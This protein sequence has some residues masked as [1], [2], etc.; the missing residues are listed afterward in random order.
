MVSANAYPVMGGVE[1]HVYEVAPRIAAAGFDVTILTTDL[2]GE[3]PPHDEIRGVPVIRVPARP[4][5]RDYYWAPD[6]YRTIRREKW[7]LVH[8]QGYHTLV[9]PL[10][11]AASARNKIPYVVTFHSGGHD[12]AA[13]NQMR[14]T[15]HLVLRPLLRRASRLIAV[16]NWEARHFADE[17]HLGI[18]RFAVIPNGAELGA[19]VPAFAEAVDVKAPLIVSVG[20][21]ERYKGHQLV[22]AALPHLLELVPGASLRI[23]GGGPFDAELRRLAAESGV[24]ERIEIGPIDA[25][26][27]A[28][29]AELLSRAAVVVAMSEYESQGIAVLEALALRRRV[30][31]ADTSAL[32]EFARSA[33]A[34]GVALDA[35]AQE[36]AEA[37]YEEL[38][39]PLRPALELPTWDQCAAALEKL[40]AELLAA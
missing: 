40:Y 36:L 16:S 7:A 3:L 38:H 14:S 27:R 28:A 13:R 1:T 24:G 33:V 4:H 17:L 6:I 8:C 37:I 5:E 11:M 26:D 12:S 32:S 9:A 29:M 18:N 39:G 25:S 34:R 19:P 10:A 30:V 20:R 15:Q 21:L 35:P 23:V 22:I 31:V 2:S